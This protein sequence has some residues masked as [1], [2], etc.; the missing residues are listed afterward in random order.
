MRRLTVKLMRCSV[1]SIDDGGERT[2]VDSSELLQKKSVKFSRLQLSLDAPLHR[3]DQED[4]VL[5]LGQLRKLGVVSTI[6]L[7]KKLL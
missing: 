6:G 5:L 7:T 1:V 3:E 2:F 4:E